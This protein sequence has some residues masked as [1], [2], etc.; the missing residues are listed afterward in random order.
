MNFNE[1]Y[2]KRKETVEQYLYKDFQNKDYP[3]KTIVEAMEYSVKCGGK[4]I[5][6]VL[7][8][9]CYN[10]FEADTDAVL[11]FCAAMEYIHTYSLIHD[12]LPCMDNDDLRRGMPTSHIKFGEAMATLAGDA[13]LNFAFEKALTCSLPETLKALKCL[14]LASGKDGMIGGQVIDIENEN[15]QIDIDLLTTLQKLKTGA[16]LS[17]SCEI[18]AIL[19]NATEAEAEILKNYGLKLGL[20]FQIK[21]DILDVTSSSEILGKPVGSDERNEKSTFVSLYGTE[22]CEKLVEQLTY[23]AISELEIFGD[24][25]DFLKELAIYLL[26]RKR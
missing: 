6:P 3:Y 11:P 7:M 13:L 5:R 18:G 22:K 19:G 14:A 15:K 4:R 16:L 12:D 17:A 1:E 9:S 8:L 10:L 25:A 26:S 20:A 21:D 23:E 2:S 24:K